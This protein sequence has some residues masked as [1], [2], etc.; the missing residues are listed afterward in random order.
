VPRY[1]CFIKNWV[2]VLC[3]KNLFHRNKWMVSCTSG[4]LTAALC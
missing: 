3:F 1:F 2:L 4:K